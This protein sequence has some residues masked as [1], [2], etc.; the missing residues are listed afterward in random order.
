MIGLW[1]YLGTGES[2]ESLRF[3]RLLQQQMIPLL[4]MESHG[5]EIFCLFV[6]E[7]N[8]ILEH[9]VVYN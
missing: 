1:K 6:D 5:K 7:D 9:L 8:L 3:F 4:C 2:P